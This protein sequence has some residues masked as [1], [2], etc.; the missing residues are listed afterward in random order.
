MN[1]DTTPDREPN[2]PLYSE[3]Y[4][5][6]LERLFGEEKAA[7]ARLPRAER[8][9]ELTRLHLQYNTPDDLDP[10]PPE[11]GGGRINP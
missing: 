9:N 3:E 4:Y 10:W 1:H 11:L 7:W 8:E 6:L 5:E 2:D